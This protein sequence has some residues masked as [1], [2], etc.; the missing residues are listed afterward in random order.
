MEV[1]LDDKKQMIM[2]LKR[3]DR[4]VT[5]I[6][7]KRTD[8]SLTRYEILVSLIK[9]GNVT[10]KVLQQSL[11]IDQAAITRHLKLLEEQQ[12]VERKRNE[13]NNREVLVNIS[14]QGRA[15]LEGC[16]MFKDQFL[17]DLYQDFSDSELQQLKQFLTRLNHN[18]EN[19]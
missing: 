15:L 8:I 12:F 14:D 17:N 1:C 5:Q 11:A 3:L 10:Q 4:H 7:E 16:T 6:F 2:M 18:V 9:N 19:L 13:K